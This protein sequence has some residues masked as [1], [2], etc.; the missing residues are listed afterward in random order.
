MGGGRAVPRVGGK[1]SG[2]MQQ[3]KKLAG[4]QEGTSPQLLSEMVLDSDQRYQG[5]DNIGKPVTGFYMDSGQ[6]I[7]TVSGK[8]I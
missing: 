7:K 3:D 2:V 5:I 8:R 4:Q 1:G 6:S